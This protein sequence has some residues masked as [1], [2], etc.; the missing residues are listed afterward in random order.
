MLVKVFWKNEPMKPGGFLGFGLTGK[1]AQGFQTE[2]NAWLRD[3]P[4][5]KIVDIKQSAS[6]GSFAGSLWLISVWYEEG[7]ES[8]AAPDRGGR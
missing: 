6:G 1:N 3:N 4:R 8:G 7:A 5:I 2:I